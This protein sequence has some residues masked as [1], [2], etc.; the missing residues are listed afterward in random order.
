[1][2]S[3]N[4]LHKRGDELISDGVSNITFQ[5]KLCGTIHSPN[6]QE[7][8]KLPRGYWVCPDKCNK[9][10]SKAEVQK[11]ILSYYENV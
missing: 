7:G 8:G 3:K 1:M 10:A 11:D 4:E 2:L 9:G 6:L 5:C